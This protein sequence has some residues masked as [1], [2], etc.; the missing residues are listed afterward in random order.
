[1]PHPTFFACSTLP[2]VATLGLWISF[3][4]ASYPETFELVV[5]PLFCNRIHKFVRP[6]VPVGFEFIIKVCRFQISFVIHNVFAE[7]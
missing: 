6:V 3:L 7:L 1:M 4:D 2:N 5:L